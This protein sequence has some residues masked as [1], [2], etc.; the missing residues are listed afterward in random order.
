MEKWTL[1]EV[2][3]SVS[4]NLTTMLKCSRNNI[5]FP[6]GSWG[7]IAHSACGISFKAK[8]SELQR[9]LRFRGIFWSQKAK[10]N[11]NISWVLHIQREILS[12][13]LQ[14]WRDLLVLGSHSCV[15]IQ[16]LIR[17]WSKEKEAASWMLFFF[18]PQRKLSPLKGS[19][20]FCQQTHSRWEGFSKVLRTA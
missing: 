15:Y 19:R 1:K 10:S 2:P 5:F 7:L 11:W 8:F 13:S 16:E 6:L 3:R 18:S 4:P 14:T 17:I 9:N 12:G 20:I